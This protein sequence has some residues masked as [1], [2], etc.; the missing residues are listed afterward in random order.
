M[1][2]KLEEVGPKLEEVGPLNDQR[3]ERKYLT[4]KLP[5][6]PSTNNVHVLSGEDYRKALI[7]HNN[8]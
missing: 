2:S 4:D 7:N 3:R 6:P 5:S 8:K 1:A